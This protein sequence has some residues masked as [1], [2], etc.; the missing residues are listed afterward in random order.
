ML[1]LDRGPVLR[2]ITEEMTQ[3]AWSLVRQGGSAANDAGLLLTRPIPDALLIE[4]WPV[5]A[6]A[7]QWRE[8]YIYS[9]HG[10]PDKP[11]A[12]MAVAVE[13]QYSDCATALLSQRLRA[14]D[15]AMRVGGAWQATLWV[16]DSQ[17]VMMRL[18]RAGVFDTQLHPGHYVAQAKD[19]GL[20]EHEELEA[21]NWPWAHL[22][23]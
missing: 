3:R 5:D 18:T 19:V 15:V 2:S 21:T 14:H 16:V 20:D 6:E 22:S 13:I 10:S 17:E 23:F 8:K 9:H 4:N 11:G 1:T 12:E 7:L